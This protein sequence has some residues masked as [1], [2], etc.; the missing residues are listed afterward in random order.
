MKAFFEDPALL[1]GLPLLVLG[2]LGVGMAVLAGLA[3]Q[4]AAA[5]VAKHAAHP[6]PEEYVKIGL[7]LG[8][9]TAVEVMIY[10][11]SIPRPLFISMLMVFSLSKFLIVLMW[12]MH[13]KFDSRLF[14][15]AFATGIV[16]AV[17]V[18]T[19]VI[20]TLGGNIV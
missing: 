3:P 5:G 4:P 6:G 20:V 7:T 14:S 17:S 9:I 1:V 12:F 8:V 2:L 19:V 18:F 11:F 10:Y 16:A 13:L 15:V